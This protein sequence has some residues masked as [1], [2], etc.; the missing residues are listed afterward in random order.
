MYIVVIP[1]SIPA[2]ILNDLIDV[3]GLLLFSATPKDGGWEALK[4]RIG[5]PRPLADLAQAADAVKGHILR[6]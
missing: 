4:D 1:D 5:A 2:A 3:A 6:S